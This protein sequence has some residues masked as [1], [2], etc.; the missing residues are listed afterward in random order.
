MTDVPIGGS[1]QPA[2]T[3]EPSIDGAGNMTPPPGRSNVSVLRGEAV[4][5]LPVFIHKIHAGEYL[6]LKG[7]YA[8]IGSEIAEFNFPQ[9]LR[10][11]SWVGNPA[12]TVEPRVGDGE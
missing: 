5:N 7:N 10:N 3:A 9:D 1:S 11:S 8:G 4:L 12:N 6:K 2:V